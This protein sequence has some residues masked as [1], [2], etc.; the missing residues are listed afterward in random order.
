MKKDTMVK[1]C[2]DVNALLRRAEASNYT[3]DPATWKEKAWAL[4]SAECR[5]ERI[6]KSVRYVG[7][8]MNGLNRRIYV[9]RAWYG[10]NKTYSI[11]LN[12]SERGEFFRMVSAFKRHPEVTPDSADFNRAS[13]KIYLEEVAI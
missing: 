7:K 12:N 3:I 5:M 13:A 11:F 9:F 2:A 6:G 8:R 4:A 10:R 1:I